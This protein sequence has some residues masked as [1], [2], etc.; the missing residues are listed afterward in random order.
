MRVEKIFQKEWK[1]VQK[2][3]DLIGNTIIVLD[4]NQCLIFINDAG[5]RTFGSSRE[6]LIGRDWCTQYLPPRERKRGITMFDQVLNEDAASP[7]QSE[8]AIITRN[9]EERIMAWRHTLL[10]DE[11]D[12]VF[13]VLSSGEDITERKRAEEALRK[14]EERFRKLAELLPQ[15]LFELDTRQYVIYSNQQGFQ[16]TGYTPDDLRAG[17]HVTQLFAQR[18]LPKL[19]QNIERILNGRSPD[20]YE[21]TLIKRNGREIP[22][23]V[24]SS[25]ILHR[26]EPVGLRGVLVDIT[27][28]KR[29]EEELRSYRHR[30]EEQVKNRTIQLQ[31]SEERQRIQY[32]KI[33][34]P[35]YTWQYKDNDFI[36][37][38]F[39]EAAETFTQ[40]YVINFLGMRASQLYKERPEILKQLNSCFFTKAAIESEMW[41]Q[42]QE[43]GERRYLS[44]KY[45][46]IA[47]DPS[48][49]TYR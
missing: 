24:Y 14:S 38:D 5:C 49:S 23:L 42:F 37:V 15:T 3:F 7:E 41:Y 4:V 36:L 45:A 22:V 47:P 10:T 12:A 18:D 46:F 30:L 26:G 28:Q 11:R 13:G 44:V 17:L 21:Y 2:Y 6:E 31:E 43:T 19:Q 40:G 16:L 25:P 8:Y 33:P 39:N 9:G 1:L 32:K 27:E 29:V 48:I 20:T 34:V 35:T